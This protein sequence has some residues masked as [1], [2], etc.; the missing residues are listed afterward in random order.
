[1]IIYIFFDFF[2][3]KFLKSYPVMLMDVLYGWHIFRTQPSIYVKLTLTFLLPVKVFWSDSASYNIFLDW[4]D[5]KVSL[6]KVII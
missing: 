1:M 5:L 2:S 4:R 3:H 6:V